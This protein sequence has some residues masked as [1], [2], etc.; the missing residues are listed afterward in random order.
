MTCLGEIP[1]LRA[2]VSRLDNAFE[3]L[4]VAVDE[5]R[6]A[7]ENVIRSHRPAGIQTWEADGGE[8]PIAKLYNVRRFPT[9]YL[10]DEDGVIRARDPFG[11][12]LIPALERVTGKKAA[13]PAGDQVSSPTETGQAGA[14]H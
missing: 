12:A 6:E 7:V 14:S 10:L 3:I 2:A 8:N 13:V 9:W 1:R 4:A 5:D 11:E